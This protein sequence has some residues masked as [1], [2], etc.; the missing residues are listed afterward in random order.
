[1]LRGMTALALRAS[2]NTVR[3]DDGQ[4]FV[5]LEPAAETMNRLPCSAA[6]PPR[7]WTPLC[8]SMRAVSEAGTDMKIELVGCGDPIT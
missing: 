3:S 8:L 6:A 1:M 2:V 4:P 5:R 7:N